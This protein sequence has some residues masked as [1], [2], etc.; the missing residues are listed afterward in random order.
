M[1]LR[2][3]WILFLFLFLGSSNLFA[4]TL[5]VWTIERPPFS[6]EEN[7]TWD[8]F[9][10]EVWEKI[11]EKNWYDFVLRPYTQFSEMIDSTE[12]EQVDVS[13]ANISITLEREERM[14][15]SYPIYDSGL[16]MMV[17]SDNKNNLLLEKFT[18]TR[19]I[20]SAI[21]ILLF[22]FILTQQKRLTKSKL[23][24]LISKKKRKHVWT[25]VVWM[26][27]LVTVAYLNYTMINM[28]FEK[29]ALPSNLYSYTDISTEIVWVTK[30]STS[31]KFAQKHNIPHITYDLLNGLYLA[32]QSWEID[33]II[34]DLPILEYYANTEW[35][36]KVEVIWE[37]FRQE[38]Y[39]VLM[40]NDSQLKEEINRALLE[41]RWSWE[42]EEIF[43]KYFSL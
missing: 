40:P 25:I 32:L 2:N 23:F 38:K 16:T 41:M 26:F 15:F 34:H 35:K 22:L 36:W 39:G 5:E 1:K 37:V 27:W 14:D 3:I 42:Y 18:D 20:I 21:L 4:K 19:V 12:T 10:I 43:E 31:E 17:K 29:Q 8:W 13:I 6:Y 7:G 28:Q 9:S 24:K 30:G 11:A 33:I